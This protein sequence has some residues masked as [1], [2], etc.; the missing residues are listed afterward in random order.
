M[1]QT[2]VI[3]F[4]GDRNGIKKKDRS[5]NVRATVMECYTIYAFLLPLDF[6]SRILFM[7]FL[8]LSPFLV[9]FFPASLFL[10]FIKYDRLTLFLTVSSSHYTFDRTFIIKH[11]RVERDLY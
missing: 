5:W 2:L 7:A 9:Y 10:L 6:F 4:R 1:L 3:N 11:G 8:G